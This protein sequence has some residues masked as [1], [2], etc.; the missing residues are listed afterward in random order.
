MPLEN[1]EE[2][3]PAPEPRTPQTGVRLQAAL[4]AQTR[5]RAVGED[6]ER[7]TH[8]GVSARAHRRHHTGHLGDRAT[9]ADTPKAPVERLHRDPRT[10]GAQTAHRSGRHGPE[11]EV[12]GTGRSEC[13]QSMSTGRRQTTITRPA[14]G[15]RECARQSRGIRCV[16]RDRR[17]QPDVQPWGHGPGAASPRDVVHQKR[18]V[19]PWNPKGRI[20]TAQKSGIERR[21]SAMPREPAVRKDRDR[22]IRARRG[23]V[24][25]ALEPEHGPGVHRERPQHR[26][27]PGPAIGVE[28]GG[29]E[30]RAGNGGGHD[31]R[32]VGPKDIDMS[33][34]YARRT[35]A[36]HGVNAACPRTAIL[37]LP[38]NPFFGTGS[39]VDVARILPGRRS[40][41]GLTVKPSAKVRIAGSRTRT[42]RRTCGLA[43]PHRYGAQGATIRPAMFSNTHSGTRGDDEARSRSSPSRRGHVR[44]RLP[45]DCDRRAGAPP[46]G[47]THCT[48]RSRQGG[49]AGRDRRLPASAIHPGSRTPRVGC[50]NVDNPLGRPEPE[51][52]TGQSANRGL[53]P[54]DIWSRAAT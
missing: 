2:R 49:P 18:Q 39:G 26:E 35:Q 51:R 3:R 38:V 14:H 29:R 41:R 8:P 15:M 32:T 10:G 30:A 23:A 42:N 25:A 5:Q 54:C 31:G 16:V 46:Q 22:H 4:H 7:G 12:A 33:E 34:L 27:H 52:G 37:V 50:R 9:P 44:E 48:E 6:V 43:A 45:P 28:H 36:V 17:R 1:L 21:G 13:A 19:A 47:P 11:P 53:A 40:V 24:E 20:Q